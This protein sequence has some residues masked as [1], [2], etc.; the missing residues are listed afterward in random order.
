M[1]LLVD[2]ATRWQRPRARRRSASRVA[3]VDQRVGAD[4]QLLA[5]DRDLREFRAEPAGAKNAASSAREDRP[6]F[7]CAS[8]V[9]LVTAERDPQDVADL[10][11]R[12]ARGRRTRS[13][14]A[15]EWS[16]PRGSGCAGSFFTATIKRLPSVSKRSTRD[17]RPS[18]KPS[19]LSIAASGS[20]RPSAV[21][22]FSIRQRLPSAIRAQNARGSWRAS[23]TFPPESSMASTGSASSCRRCATARSRRPAPRCAETTGPTLALHGCG[24]ALLL[25]PDAKRDTERGVPLCAPAM[26]RS[27]AR[28]P[29]ST[30]K[31]RIVW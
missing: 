27:R 29:V 31:K 3:L 30:W 11:R 22:A 18:T 15:P 7:S 20:L 14:R 24:A 25:Q 28:P 8:A 4:Q 6:S 5:P 13:L 12:T 16:G 21:R 1:W 17:Q 10:F 26:N 9:R 2:P 19:Q 23:W